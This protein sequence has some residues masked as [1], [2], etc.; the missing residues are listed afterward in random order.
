MPRQLLDPGR[1]L[2]DWSAAID[3][4]TSLPNVDPNRVGVWGS[5]FG[6]GHAISIAARESGRVRAAVAQCPFTNG[7]SSTFTVGLLPL[8]GI[9]LLSIR[10][11]IASVA[12]S[13]IVPVPLAAKPGQVALMNAPDVWEGYLN[14]VPEDKRDSFPNYVAARLALTFPLLAPG[15]NAKK[16]KC[17]IL[18]AVCGKDTVAPA[19]KTLKYAKQAPKGVIKHYEEMG[20]F[21]IY[22]G[23]HFEKAARDYVAFF[24]QHLK[25]PA[26]TAK[27]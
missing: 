6:G 10:D 20:H 17:P 23:N 1:Q 3:Y 13:D 25:E 27:L 19:A 26:P 9:T 14:L 2:E 11:L 4:I 15:R 21:S 24:D 18:F 5:S 16:V 12:S 22:T 8:L 7:L